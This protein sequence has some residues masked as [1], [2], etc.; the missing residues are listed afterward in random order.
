MAQCLKC[1]S[2]CVHLMDFDNGESY[3]SE[4]FDL[5]ITQYLNCG[6]CGNVDPSLFQAKEYSRF[7]THA[8]I[9]LRHRSLLLN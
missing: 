6:D 5:N 7:K 2:N 1:N 3:I 4:G 9:F 8:D